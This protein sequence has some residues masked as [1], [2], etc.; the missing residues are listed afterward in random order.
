MKYFN[1]VLQYT[2]TT[3]FLAIFGAAQAGSY[4][5]FFKAIALDQPQTISALLVRGFDPNTV[6]PDG[7]PALVKALQDQSFK[8]AQ[9]L[10]QSPQIQANARN[11][12]EETALMLA[13]LRGQDALALDLV[14]RGAAINKAGWTPLHY[15][16]TGGH[17][18]ICA[19]LIGAGADVNAESPNGT[20]PLMMAAM[21]GNSAVVK[22]M[23]ESGAEAY[24][25]N[26][27]GLSAQD[28]ARKAGR[29]DSARLIQ[30]VLER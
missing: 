14:A 20:T 24:T 13:A 29:E 18:L 3:A 9:A 26:D 7:T 27:Q 21:Y 11:N 23:L 2:V 28:F 4:E 17:L 8:A 19:F 1:K 30:Q 5:D 22:L 6:H 16:A 15:A 12:R 10:L 25:R